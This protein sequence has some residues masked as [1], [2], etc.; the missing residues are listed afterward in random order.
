MPTSIG[1]SGQVLTTDGAN[2]TYWSNASGSSE[3]KDSE[4]ALT[5]ATGKR[6][7]YDIS[8]IDDSTTRTISIPNRNINL[9]YASLM[10]QSV[11]TGSTPQFAGIGLR[12]TGTSTCT[13]SAPTTIPTSYTLY[14]PNTGVTPTS[15]LKATNN[16]LQWVEDYSVSTTVDLYKY[17][18]TYSISGGGTALKDA[19]A[20]HGGGT[21]G[22]PNVYEITD[23][24]TYDA[25]IS[26]TNMSYIVIRGAIGMRPTVSVDSVS[27]VTCFSINYDLTHGSNT[28]VVLGNMDANLSGTN[29]VLGH[30]FLICNKQGAGTDTDVLNGIYIKDVY[31]YNTDY[32]TTNVSRAG[33]VVLNQV[34]TP[35]RWASNVY[36]EDC[37]FR[38]LTPRT[39]RGVILMMGVNNY[40]GLRNKVSSPDIA[41]TAYSS[42]ECV[43][44]ISSSGAERLSS[45]ESGDM[46]QYNSDSN[47]VCVDVIIDQ[48][49]Y[50]GYGSPIEFTFDRCKLSHSQ[51]TTHGAIKI[52]YKPNEAGSLGTHSEVMT[53]NV[54]QCTFCNNTNA[55]V[56]VHGDGVSAA[57]QGISLSIDSC[58]FESTKVPIFKST[59][60]VCPFKRIYVESNE[61]INCGYPLTNIPLNDISTGQSVSA[62]QYLSEESTIRSALTDGY[63]GSITTSPVYNTPNASGVTRHNYIVY[64]NPSGS[65]SVASACVASFDA[66]AGV[67]KA[68]DAATTKTTPGNVDAWLK[69]NISGVV[70][71]VPAFLSKTS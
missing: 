4:F 60:Y 59:G 18:V 62:R 43:R 71:Y 64:S 29:A 10:D 33:I 11:S 40:M 37:R 67:H 46:L 52:S 34:N 42:R 39:D 17:P 35:L 58:R 69:V 14:M 30:A 38:N 12:D 2:Q 31:M 19:I 24:L 53:I 57:L 13:L 6:L 20:L 68:V 50:S 63:N 66:A 70:Y 26:L 55:G 28:Y 56:S 48:Y 45:I 21:L 5:H 61:Y 47:A 25:G 65:S 23:N 3:F 32:T 44:F 16:Q 7:V 36:I 27:N 1:T 9:N 51:S 54:S 8:S 15:Y 22:S 49:S 41:T